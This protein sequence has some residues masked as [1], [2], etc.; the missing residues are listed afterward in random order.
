MNW[1]KNAFA[2][3]PPGPT[4]PTESQAEVVDWVCLQIVKR[5]LTTPALITLEMS[6]PMNFIGSQVM[7]FLEPF[8]SAILMTHGR[9]GYDEFAAFLEHRGSLDFMC[10]RIEELEAE[11]EKKESGKVE[12]SGRAAKG[13]TQALRVFEVDA[14]NATARSRD[15]R[16]LGGGPLGSHAGDDLYVAPSE[17]LA[18]DHPT[19]SAVGSRDGNPDAQTNFPRPMI[20]QTSSTSS[21]RT[22]K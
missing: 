16:E 2:V 1:F 7:R 6:R 20:G 17:R 12:E 15:R 4:E 3:D 9:K 5:H 21:P 13:V 18:H 14:G 19:H 11:Y 10:R 22:A 8:I